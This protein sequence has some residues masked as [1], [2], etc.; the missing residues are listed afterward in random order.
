M[1]FRSNNTNSYSFVWNPGNLS[2]S[3]VSVTP[4]TT[5]AYTLT[6]TNPGNSCSSTATVNVN[7]NQLPP[8]PTATPSEQCGAGIPTASVASNSGAA[9][10]RFRWYLNPTGGSP[11]QD[12]TLTT[13]AQS[14]IVS[15]SFYV[16]EISAAGCEG[17]R[18][19]VIA[20]VNQP[21]QIAMTV[22]SNSVCL[23]GTL[24]IASSYTPV[25][26]LYDT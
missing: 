11:V 19:M 26:N 25:N 3:S 1:L 20:T 23:G 13:Y 22:S 16:S 4:S 6:V 24:T 7:V 8:A 12:S 2:G 14:I 18:V 21:D 17:A 5:T 10:P 9:T 15:D